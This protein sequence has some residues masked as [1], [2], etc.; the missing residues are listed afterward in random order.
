MHRWVA[1]VM[2]TVV[3]GALLFRTAP[4]SDVYF[5]EVSLTRSVAKRLILLEERL[6]SIT[7]MIAERGRRL[8]TVSKNMQDIDAL[9]D[10]LHSTTDELYAAVSD[11]CVQRSEQRSKHRSEQRRYCGPGDESWIMWDPL[12]N[13]L[14]VDKDATCT[15]FDEYFVNGTKSVAFI[16]ASLT[17]HSYMNLRAMLRNKVVT[18]RLATRCDRH[19]F[20]HVKGPMTR[21]KGNVGPPLVFGKEHPGCTDCSGC[22]SEY[23]L[24][25]NGAEIVYT[26]MEFARD[27]E[28]HNGRDINTT[29]AAIARYLTETMRPDVVVMSFGTH[30]P[31]L[32][33]P[34]DVQYALDILANDRPWKTIFVI[35]PFNR[36]DNGM[37]QQMRSNAAMFRQAI[38]PSIVTL[39]GTLLSRR[40]EEL[41]REGR[42]HEIHAHSYT[43]SVHPS[44]VYYKLVLSLLMNHIV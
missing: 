10:R 37:N 17:Y 25:D 4:S 5:D 40:V 7:S 26:P 19:K 30:G 28:I 14:V 29:Q 6:E 15:V 38:P 9:A 20:L 24:L 34:D 31:H 41:S 16:G 18:K 23:T 11:R 42:Q 3:M 13:A 32:I 36:D 12:S 8:N 22:N 35:P 44:I 33:N 2:C 21:P 43:D 1:V 39:D 27:H